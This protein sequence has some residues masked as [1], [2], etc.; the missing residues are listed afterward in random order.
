LSRQRERGCT[1]HSKVSEI[2]RVRPRAGRWTQANRQAQ[3]A[4]I[5]LELIGRYGVKGTTMERIARAAGIST[6]A[7]YNH[8][9]GKDQILEAAQEVLLARSLQWLHSSDNPNMLERLREL[10]GSMHQSRVAAD[11]TWLVLPL[12]NFSVSTATADPAHQ[13]GKGLEKVLERF[14]DIIEAGKD[15]GTIRK[16]ADSK[17]VAWSL[18]GLGWTADFSAIQ[19]HHQ[20]VTDG[21]SVK[22]LNWI[23]SNIAV[24]GAGR[25]E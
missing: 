22:I 17:M 7:L 19:G 3:I 20:F 1:I 24:D 23:L 4:E 2:T 18:I 15:Q 11:P 13:I 6:P 25:R 12:F 21:T 9:A 10:V 16:S 8:F 5:T 14:V